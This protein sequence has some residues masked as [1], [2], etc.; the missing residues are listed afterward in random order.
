MRK[1]LTIKNIAIIVLILSLSG[2]FYWFG[3][4]WIQKEK[5]K[6][7]DAGAVQMRDDIFQIAEQNKNITI[8]NSEGKQIILIVP[9]Q[10]EE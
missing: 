7:F 4:Q 3:S 2:N 9:S 10:D 5:Q 1:F 8:G 6:Y